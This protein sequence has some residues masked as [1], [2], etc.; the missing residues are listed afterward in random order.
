MIPASSSAHARTGRAGDGWV[1]VSRRLYRLYPYPA[2][3]LA[4]QL[5]LPPAGAFNH[6]T[7]A[8]VRGWW[9]PP[10]P[11][12]VPVFAAV[13]DGQPRPRREGLVIS[14][15]TQRIAFDELCGLRVARPEEILLAAARDLALLDMVVLA[16]AALHLGECTLADLRAASE[17]RRRGAPAL[18]RALSYVDGRSESAWESMLRM[19]HRV[20]DLP[21][22]PQHVVRDEDGSF[23]ARAALWLAGTR[24]LAEYD[25]EVHRSAAQHARDLFRDR[26]L[27]RLGWERYGYTADVVLH[28]GVSVLRDGDAALGREHDPTRIRG[29]HRLLGESLFTAAGT[30]RLQARWALQRQ[31]RSESA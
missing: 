19:L 15:H 30:A 2:E 10:L 28:R 29:W 3:L 9:V 1:R 5:A 22:V 17:R 7:A 23:V 18:R 26:L 24:R 13:L 16:D 20:C 8:V 4:W 21:V 6:L 11:T 27:R 31:H 14:R 12:D 25:G